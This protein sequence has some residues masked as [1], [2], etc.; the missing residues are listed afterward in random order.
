MRAMSNK[1]FDHVAEILEFEELL[2]VGHNLK[3]LELLDGLRHS[4]QAKFLNDGTCNIEE[5]A[6]NKTI[7]N[8]KNFK[9]S[10]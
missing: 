3:K 1:S 10:P 7:L 8:Q 9:L 2:E 6:I 4:E 5:L